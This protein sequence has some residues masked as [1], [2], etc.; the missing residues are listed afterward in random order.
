MSKRIWM[1][2]L[3]LVLVILV[4]WA[5]WRLAF[6]DKE[7]PKQTLTT[8]RFGMLPY[9]DHTYAVIGAK[10][11]WFE[12]VG[13]KLDYRPIK[14]EDAVPFVRNKSL[15][16][17]SCPPGIVI[18]AFENN[19]GVVSFVFGDVFQGYA[20]MA[21]ADKGLKTVSDFTKEGLPIDQ[22]I[23]STVRQMRG[24][25]FAYPAEAAIK[26]FIDLALRK[27]DLAK[28]DIKSLVLDDP[29]TVNA[30]RKRQADFQVGGVPSRLVLQR[31]GF[32]PLLTSNDLATAAK[33]SPESE[34][35][36]SVF[37]DG[38]ICTREYYQQNRDL[39]LR[40]ASVNF[41]ITRFINEHMDEALAIHMPYLSQVTGQQ[42]T[43][44]EG[45]IIYTSLDPFFT[46][47]AQQEWFHNPNNPYFFQN[48]NGAII[49]SFEKQKIFQHGAPTVAD[50]NVSDEV[51]RTLETLKANTDALLRQV[52]TSTSKD[53]PDVKANINLARRQYDAYNFLDAERS[54]KRAAGIK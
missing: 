23:R 28:A 52:E 44:A 43:P 50:V 27:G 35:L 48:L 2:A 30:M 37:T 10:K 36:S 51:Y 31:E 1:S 29:L 49:K 19:P 3:L 54:A 41:R 39:V 9:G 25:T 53:N 40:M 38:W 47:E 15:D 22:A 21:R 46:F 12:E 8:V 4:G 14:I 17:A 11:G 26:P 5:V 7:E 45:K 13:I 24:A 20:L 32:I 6:T 33:P 42:F 34:E 18:A 16:V